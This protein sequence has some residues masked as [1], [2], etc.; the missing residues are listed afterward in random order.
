MAAKERPVLTH[1]VG[2]LK[3]SV[4]RNKKGDQSWYT[5]MLTRSY[6]D[7]SGEWQETPSL[8][9]C[10]LVVAANMLERIFGYCVASDFSE[11]LGSDTPPSK[12]Q[13]P[14]QCTSQENDAIPF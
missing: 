8:N 7:A 2:H 6:R 9:L 10:D 13:T 1:R 4:W 5:A 3:I 14:A 12:D 11:T